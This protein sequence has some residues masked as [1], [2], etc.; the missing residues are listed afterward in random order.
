MKL[1]Q[2]AIKEVVPEV[3]EDVAGEEAIN[4]FINPY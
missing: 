1:A 4:S 3:Q 2:D